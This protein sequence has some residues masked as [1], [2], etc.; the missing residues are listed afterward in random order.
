MQL[1]KQQDHLMEEMKQDLAN[2]DKK[3]KHKDEVYDKL[4]K[5]V[6]Q[7]INSLN[8][9]SDDHTNKLNLTID[10]LREENMEMDQKL[11]KFQTSIS[12]ENRLKIQ[13]RTLEQTSENQNLQIKEHEKKIEDMEHE[14]KWEKKNHALE[15]DQLNGDIE[16]AK[17]R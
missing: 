1:Q 8:N 12:N 7:R 4:E 17:T 11:R 5:S 3:L 2:Y 15:I 16:K 13:I 9:V 14:G 6:A 10:Q